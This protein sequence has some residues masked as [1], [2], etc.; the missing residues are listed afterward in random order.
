M[1]KWLLAS[2]VIVA[3]GACTVFD[4][5]SVPSDASS[6]TSPEA[7]TPETGGGDG[8]APAGF[9]S[10]DDAVKF[11]ANA[12][13]CPWLPSSIITDYGVP[14]DALHFSG[15]VNWIAG[16][17]PPDRVG[18]SLQAKWLKCAADAKTCADTSNC[19]WW[20]L[21]DPA[22]DPRCAT[23]KDA[24]PFGACAE[25]AGAAYYCK[26][27][28]V[29]HCLHAGYAPG[30]SCLTGTNGD[31]RCALSKNCMTPDSCMS[32]YEVYCGASSN[33]REGIDCAITGY[34]CGLDPM[35][36]LIQCL[37]EGQYKTCNAVA[38]TCDQ[39]GAIVSVCD[40][41]QVNEYKCTS[42]G[43]TCDNTGSVP[44][45]KIPNETCSPYDMAEDQCM[46][47]SI[48]MCVGGKKLNYDCSKV[49]LTCKPGAGAV[50]AHCG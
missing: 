5:L 30:S 37:T 16:P 33:L 31:H 40:G 35:G 17:I 24:G 20:E 4:G 8:G 48:S 39:N 49:G 13:K 26:D 28:I 29:A 1:K 34:T 21:M 19:L 27:G 45:C 12:F 6:E 10:I 2:V 7:S 9:L 42:L 23:M 41:A 32:S 3:S 15:C 38:V 14:V 25:D 44:R 47:T 18:A 50:S 36:G 46:G 43:G 11:C 22:T